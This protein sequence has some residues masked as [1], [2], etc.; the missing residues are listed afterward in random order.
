[1]STETPRAYV[2]LALRRDQLVERLETGWQMIDD[3]PEATRR[4]KLEI[5]WLSLL[6]AYEECDT[7]LTA[8][9]IRAPIQ[10][11]LL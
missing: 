4:A 11:A 1:M 5:H 8:L 3:E 9:E 2:A 7:Q 10:G 6:R